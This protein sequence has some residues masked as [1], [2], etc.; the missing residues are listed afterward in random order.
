LT[1]DMLHFSAPVDD[2][3]AGIVMATVV[4][5]GSH[6]TLV[7][8]L[9]DKVVCASPTSDVFE[10]EDQDKNMTNMVTFQGNV[11]C[12]DEDGWVYKFVAPSPMRCDK[13]PRSSCPD[14]AGSLLH[15]F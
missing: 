6:P 1:G 2:Y 10:E 3:L 13:K 12:S 5:G 8:M 11:Y 14:V 9:Y 4:S 7:F 15:T